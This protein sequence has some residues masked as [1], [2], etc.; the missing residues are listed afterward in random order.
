MNIAIASDHGGWRLKNELRDRLTAA[1]HTVEDLGGSAE[2]SDYPDL[3]ASVGRAVAEGRADKGILVCGSGIGVC[4]AANKV[5]GVRA[6]TVHET[7]SARLFREHNDGNVLCLGE[8]LVGPEMAWEVVQTFLGTDHMEEPICMQLDPQDVHLLA[9]SG[10]DGLETPCPPQFSSFRAV[11][12]S[13]LARVTLV[14]PR[15]DAQRLSGP[16]A[17]SWVTRWRDE[18]VV[19]PGR[20]F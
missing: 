20:P 12:A 14:A 16:D 7:V 15:I 4:I 5:S 13:D 1:G 8:R 3:A 17:S 2:R 19:D 11:H 6:A 9:S 18:Q 10:I